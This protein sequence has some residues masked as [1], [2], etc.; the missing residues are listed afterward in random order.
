M[1]SLHNNFNLPIKVHIVRL[2]D[3]CTFRRYYLQVTC[4]F[5]ILVPKYLVVCLIVFLSFPK[6]S[7]KYKLINVNYYYQRMA[8]ISW[9]LLQSERSKICTLKMETAIVDEATIQHVQVLAKC[10]ISKADMTDA[11]E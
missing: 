8:P 7:K 6:I 11:V 9:Q 5:V 10:D 2:T 3:W 4:W 1:Y